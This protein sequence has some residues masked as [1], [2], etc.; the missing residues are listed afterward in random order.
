MSSNFVAGFAQVNDHDLKK[1][2]GP[3]SN[4][5]PKKRR[6]MLFWFGGMVFEG[7]PGLPVRPELSPWRP[8][9]RWLLTDRNWGQG[10]GI[11]S[12]RLCSTPGSVGPVQRR[13]SLVVS[14]PT[15]RLHPSCEC[16]GDRSLKSQPQTCSFLGIRCGFSTGCK[17]Q[18]ESGF[19]GSLPMWPQGTRGWASPL[20]AAALV[21][22]HG[23]QSVQRE[24][25]SLGG[26]DVVQLL[27]GTEHRAGGSGQ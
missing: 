25:V 27:C 15:P 7:I 9:G 23:S 3:N 4:Q 18:V 14:R 13:L 19:C 12:G 16:G 24:P 11:C 21:G 26:P 5:F 6:G 1:R 17:M 22:T 8:P 20:G 10:V 2:S